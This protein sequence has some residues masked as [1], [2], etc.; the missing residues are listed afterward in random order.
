MAEVVI[1]TAGHVDHGKTAL[2]RA[3]TGQDTDRLPEERRRGISIDLGFA[4]F[5]LPSGR[6]AGIVD[7]PGHERFIKNMVAGASG[8][9]LVLLVVAAD[10]G[11]MPQTRE[12]L[13]ILQLLGV[14][15][16]VVVITKTDLVDDDWLDLVEADLRSE[17]ARSFLAGAPVLRVSS[18]TGA[19]LDELRSVVDNLLPRVR[20]RPEDAHARLPVD[21]V[22][23]VA[24]F[25]TVVTG[26]LIAGR[27]AVDDRLEVQPGRREVRVRQVQVH[28]R[29]VD[30]AEAGQRVALN[31]AG[32]AVDELARGQVLVTPSTLVA[33]RTLAAACTL[34]D[35]AERPLKNGARVRLHIGT[36]EVL[37]RLLLL[38]RDALEPG[39]RGFAQFQAEEPLV[40][41]RGDRCIIRSYSPLR[42]IGG[43]V[44]LD[45]GQRYRRYRAESLELLAVL[46][47]GSLKDVVEALLEREAGP[48]DVAGFA[49][50]LNLPLERLQAL[51]GDLAGRVVALAG[52]GLVASV[53]VHR[54][55]AGRIAEALDAYHRQFPL[56]PGMPREA[57][58]AAVLPRAD[59]R[60]FGALLDHLAADG[61][62]ELDGD[63]VRVPGFR[64]RLDERLQ[65]A[66]ESIH[67][68]FRDAGAAPPTRAGAAA[69]LGLSQDEALALID[70]LV[71]QGRL[72]RVDEDF[73]LD[74][75]VYDRMVD[76]IRELLEARG[77][78]TVAEIRDALGTT[79]KYVLPLLEHLDRRSVTRRMGD[80]R[81]LAGRGRK[82]GT[83]RGD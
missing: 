59:A 35:E 53:S 32:I 13:Q 17:L 3:L 60:A 58:R 45:P 52:G 76:R 5:Q 27:I 70:M 47:S 54:R 36:S 69:E 24:G 78:A 68:R 40:A 77:S 8:I 11:V 75:A 16:G 10:E 81:Q 38:D 6:R 46:D 21:R 56:R 31:L 51:L 79:R 29:R 9:D 25:G 34:L 72:V 4:E 73:Y 22:F 20:R 41:A 71:A 57:L 80:V 74:T 66:L 28:G 12:H 49:R 23:R 50:R 15:S 64:P 30:V 48:V 61:R 37:G 39:Q 26:T 62:V 14:E 33:V 67:A 63:A 42:T 2:I 19:G 65:A 44:V 55:L 82:E 7:V 83:S 1:G 43:G 18:K